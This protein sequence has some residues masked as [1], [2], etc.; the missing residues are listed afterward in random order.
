MKE[1]ISII[2]MNK[3]SA[4]K[5]ALSEAGYPAF[6][7]EKVNGRGK[8]MVNTQ[9]LNDLIKGDEI[10]SPEVMETITENDRLLAKRMLTI[11]VPDEDAKKIIDIIIDVNQ[12][13]DK[14]D[15]KIFVCPI[16]EAMRIRTGE[17]GNEAI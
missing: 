16:D 5:E 4:T 9:I 13:G 2:R 15:G 6:I 11:V 14:G 10:S 12:T 7:G 1:I 17:T 3:V 8:L